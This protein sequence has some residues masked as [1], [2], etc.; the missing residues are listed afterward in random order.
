M[1]K[2]FSIFM[3]LALS[4]IAY[5]NPVLERQEYMRDFSKLMK[6]AKN[7]VKDRSK[8]EDLAN[9]FEEIENIM[10]IYPTLF[11]DDSFGG[12]SK[13]STDIIDNRDLFNQ[14]AKETEDNA[15]FAKLAAMKGDFD[16]VQQYHK[17]LYG[18]CKS[19]HSRFKD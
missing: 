4:S 7:L 17:K 16:E 9:A 10:I 14:I 8:S 11:P 13:A 3:M 19:C 2:I 6:V 18:S 1:I 15:A 5:S 12:K